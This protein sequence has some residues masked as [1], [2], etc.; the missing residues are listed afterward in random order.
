MT[1]EGEKERETERRVTEREREREGDREK[2]TE[3]KVRERERE[4]EREKVTERMVTER[5]L[6]ERRLT[7]REREI[8]SLSHLSIQQWVR[9]S[10]ASQHIATIH[11]SPI[12]SYL[13]NFRHRVVRSY[14]Q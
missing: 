8:Q 3:R 1:T 6:T 5:R 14:C 12:V 9:S 13:W 7:E 11:I 4:G 2:V 10:N